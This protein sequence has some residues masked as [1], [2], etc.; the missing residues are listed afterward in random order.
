MKKANSIAVSE[1]L[2]FHRAA[3]ERSME[4]GQVVE[5]SVGGTG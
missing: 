2:K 3:Y 5:L 4:L 1:L